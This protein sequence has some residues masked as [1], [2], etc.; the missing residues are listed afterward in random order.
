MITIN[1]VKTA[2]EALEHEDAGIRYHGAWWLG[3][4]RVVEA[5]PQVVEALRGFVDVILEVVEGVRPGVGAL[6]KVVGAIPQVVE[7]LRGSLEL[8]APICRATAA[9]ERPQ[10]QT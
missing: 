9:A 5:I 10:A 1:S 8:R 2:L 4:N 3:K 6:R 7:A